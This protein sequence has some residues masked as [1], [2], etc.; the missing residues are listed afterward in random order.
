MGRILN[1]GVPNIECLLVGC[2]LNG[3]ASPKRLPDFIFRSPPA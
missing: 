1:R 2:I 3:G